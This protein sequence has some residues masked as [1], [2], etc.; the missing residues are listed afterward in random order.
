MLM[1]HADILPI[2]APEI[3][4]GFV[5]IRDGKIEAVGEM[6]NAPAPEPG[7]EVVELGGRLLLPGFV[8]A[9]SHMGLVED[10]VGL[11]GDDLNEDSDPATP[12]MRALDGLN[13]LDRSFAEARES[14]VTCAVISPGSTNPVGGQVCAVKTFGRWADKMAVAQ[15]LA[16]KFSMGENPKMTYSLKPAAPVT[17]MGT[18]AIIREQLYKAKRYLADLRRA[19]SE[20]GVDEPEYDLRCESLLPLLR[21]EIRAHFHAHKA[22]DIL[23]AVRIAQEFSLNYTLIHCTEGYL[24][25]DILG[26]LGARAVCGPLICA[27]TKPELAGHSLQSAARLLRAGVV[28]AISTDHPELP[29]SFLLSSAALAAANGLTREEA[30]GCITLSAARAVGLEER[31][32]SVTPGK[33]ADLLVFEQDP[34]TVCAKPEQVYIGGARVI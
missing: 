8:D 1:L 23:T 28:T 27:R 14:G 33:D 22:Y 18:A 12:Q 34:F 5:R 11:E 29:G 31:L 15:P 19:Q 30:L 24:I 16:V 3:A 7:E 17:R 6:R 21:G 32:G 25:A 4:A 13:P 26:E 2:D 9:H 20:E 10:G